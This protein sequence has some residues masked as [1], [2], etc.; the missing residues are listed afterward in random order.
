LSVVKVAWDPVVPHPCP[1]EGDRGVV[2]GQHRARTVAR[3]FTSGRLWTL[4]TRVS[5]E[6]M[7]HV[8]E[9]RTEP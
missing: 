3:R 9:K 1:N 2:D 5:G 8:A 7:G 4:R 6:M